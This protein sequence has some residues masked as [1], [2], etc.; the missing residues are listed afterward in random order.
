MYMLVQQFT[1]IF[2]NREYM[3]V[4]LHTTLHMDELLHPYTGMCNY[5][6]THGYTATEG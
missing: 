5:R 6:S 3:D 4:P 1:W 2:M